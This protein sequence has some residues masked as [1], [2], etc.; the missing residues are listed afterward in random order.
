MDNQATTNSHRNKL[1]DEYTH[2]IFVG[3]LLEKRLTWRDTFKCIM[4][5]ASSMH[6]QIVTKHFRGKITI[7]GT[8]KQLIIWTILDHKSN[9]ETKLKQTLHELAPMHFVVF[10]DF[11]SKRNFYIRLSYIEIKLMFFR[12]DVL[13]KNLPVVS[14]GNPSL[15]HNLNWVGP[16]LWWW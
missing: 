11:A 10:F 12:G 15:W 16:D 2:V 3:K 14:P 1:E 5:T 8:Q 13:T 7:L 4:L 6:V 9:A